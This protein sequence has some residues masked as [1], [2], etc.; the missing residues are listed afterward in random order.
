MLLVDKG[1]VDKLARFRSWVELSMLY[2]HPSIVLHLDF[3]KVRLKFP[4]KFN[5]SWNQDEYVGTP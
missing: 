1:L 2:N 5:V 4:F 3:V